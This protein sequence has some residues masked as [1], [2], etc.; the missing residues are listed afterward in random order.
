M[1]KGLIFATTLAMVLGVGV[2]VGAHQGK[3]AAEVK[4]AAFTVYL[5]PNIWATASPN[6]E[7]Y[8]WGPS[9]GWVA[10]SEVTTD[11][12][13]YEATLPDGTTG[14]SFVRMDPSKPADTWSSAWNQTEDLTFTA[15][16]PCYKVTSWDGG[17]DGKS[18]GSWEAY[19]KPAAASV[20]KYKIGDAAAVTMTKDTGTEYVS[21]ELDFAKGDV[22]SFLKDDAAYAV[23]PKDSG[24][25]TRVYSVTGGLKFAEAY[26]GALYLETSTAE[27][28]AG[29]FTPGYY[30]V[31]AK[32]EWNAKL[33][34]KASLESGENPQAYVVQ[35]VE[36]DAGDEL[37]FVQF[38]SADATIDYYSA[39]STKV[40]TGSEVEYSVVSD[41]YDGYNL[42]V[43]N[44]GTYDI[45]YNPSSEWYSIEDKNWSPDIPANEGYYL[46]GSFGGVAKWRYEVA[47][48]M[49]NTTGD[50]V[51]HLMNVSMAANDEFRV[52]SYFT[53]RPDSGADDQWATADSTV[54]SDTDPSKK[55]VISGD[56]LKVKAAGYY[57]IYAYYDGNT[58]MFSAA[59]HVDTYAISFTGV[60]FE[61]KANTGA[62]VAFDDQLA[63]AGSNFNPNL[64]Y[65]SES[66]YVTRG[67]YTD[68]ACTTAYVAH[69]YSAAGQLYVK[70]TRTG[71]YVQGDAAFS[72]SAAT[73]WNIDGSVYL[74]D[75]VNDT[76]NNVL[77][78][79]VTIPASASETPVEVRPFEYM[80]DGTVNYVP[81]S[82]GTTYSFASKVGDNLRFTKG[83][84]FAVYVNKSY[85]VYLNEGAAAFYTKF[86]TDTG[87]VCKTNNTTDLERLGE[88]WD[89]LEG[90]YDSLSPTEKTTIQAV[91]FDGGDEHGDDLHK[92]MARYAYIVTKYGSAAFHNFIFPNADEIA[93]HPNMTYGALNI[94]NSGDNT[95]MIVIIAIAASSAL[96]FGAFL[97]LKKR[98][99]K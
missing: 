6:Y 27:L 77:E 13:V 80:D 91:G 51:A 92:V 32:G 66:G 82:L 5:K 14:F 12:G 83:G 31:G 73:A 94:F 2:A 7:V 30:L 49:T 23:T 81:Y 10:M 97:Y 84:T 55:F 75:A 26:H 58:F 3:A 40:N 93:P 86:L 50:N 34:L 90:V 25:Q 17:T 64:N 69:E 54:A 46:C 56:N 89:E 1:K 24:K 33:G 39:D 74:P 44:A 37:K 21:A 42:K 47:T 65:L 52:R 35:N 87:A 19:T 79:S 41:G 85:Q 95:M 16:T 53:N 68:A 61:G 9:S 78:G 38:A 98:K 99:Q 48:K 63:Y 59:E 20:Y 67:V 15:A 8:Y 4:A 96:A 11:N 60:K 29:Q 70:L 45:Y 28:W 88:V 22:V 57:D 76:E 72:G 36:L 62:T 71:Y 18:S 43:T